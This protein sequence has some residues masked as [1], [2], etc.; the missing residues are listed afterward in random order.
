MYQS[1]GCGHLSLTALPKRKIKINMF[2]SKQDNATRNENDNNKG[3]SKKEHSIA[4]SSSKDSKY[5]HIGN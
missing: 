2:Q 4:L 1:W 5:I 3:L